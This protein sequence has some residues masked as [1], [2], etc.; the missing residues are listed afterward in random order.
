MTRITGAEIPFICADGRSQISKHLNFLLIA[1][2]RTTQEFLDF[3]VK[4][5]EKYHFY[6]TKTADLK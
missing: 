5:K 3:R 6:F 2:R 1:S 4:L